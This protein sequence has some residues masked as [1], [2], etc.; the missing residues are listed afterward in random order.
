[1]HCGAGRSRIASNLQLHRLMAASVPEKCG[2][3]DSVLAVR[4]LRRGRPDVRGPQRL[5]VLLEA[6]TPLPVIWL[7]DNRGRRFKS[8][9]E[10]RAQEQGENYLSVCPAVLRLSGVRAAN[11]K[12]RTIVE[13]KRLKIEVPG[14]G[15]DHIPL[16]TA[17]GNI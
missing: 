9:E 17:H 1:M 15:V 7:C 3:A 12:W 16:G 13:G 10:V 4:L 14:A 5:N 11:A 2:A 6:F 8:E